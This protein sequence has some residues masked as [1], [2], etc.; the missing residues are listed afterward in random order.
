MRKGVVLL[1][2]ASLLVAWPG[3]QG[4]WAQGLKFNSMPGDQPT[5]LVK[6]ETPGSAW[7]AMTTANAGNK[8][9]FKI[10]YHCG[11]EL[12]SSALE[13]ARNTT[14]RLTLPSDNQSVQV[15]PAQVYADNTGVT[16]ANATL[17]LGSPQ[18]LT[19]DNA[20]TRLDNQGNSVGSLTLNRGAG[21]VQVSFGDV[22]CDS[23]GSFDHAG[24][25]VF[26]ATLSGP[27]L[28]GVD[29][30]VNNADGPLYVDYNS[31]VTLNWTTSGATT[32]LAG[33]DWTGSRPTAGS[34]LTSNLLSSKNYVLVCNGPQGQA[35]DSV[36]VFISAPQTLSAT[37][38]AT[39]NQGSAP[40]NGV[41]LT[42]RVAGSA[43]GTIN[44]KFDCTSDGVWDY[45]LTAVNDNPKTVVNACNYPVPGIYTAK[46]AVERGQAA[47][48]EALTQISVASSQ[49]R[50]L[51]VSGQVRDLSAGTAFAD[52]LT[53]S[54]GDVLEFQ[55]VLTNATQT[56]LS[57]LK[58][59]ET[60]AGKTTYSGLLKI[61][62]R[63]DPGDPLAGLDLGTLNPGQ[64][65]SVTFQ[66]V[67]AP[68]ANFGPGST[69]L[70]NTTLVYNVNLARTQS[71]TIS[72]T[73]GQVLGA[74]TVKT[75]LF[76]NFTWSLFLAL[77]ATFL[78]TYLGL[79]RFYFGQRRWALTL[80]SI[81][82]GMDLLARYAASKTEQRLRRLIAEIRQKEKI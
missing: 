47:P 60:L 81:K 19:F 80:P 49:S 56:V 77:L 34:E 73:K 75:G 64:S 14:V 69:S 21:Y 50:D 29:L 30:K 41:N 74:T 51:S 55:M 82:P 65:R 18:N 23:T 38:T 37:L 79:A 17:S 59:K 61:D 48:T 8:L 57:N 44:Y 42:A 54:P 33:G 13:K 67:L 45:S 10:Y 52:T 22:T 3:F 36:S 4:V 7:S 68:A 9:S 70:V 2:L 28:P 26:G 43:T 24:S 16:T 32:C 39:P 31:Q 72:V 71:V 6:N 15:L 5:V 62:N 27:V 58:L 46:V 1:L 76:D 53:A 35:Q 25:V 11:V 40:L 20:V 63:D 66:A 12:A 78:V